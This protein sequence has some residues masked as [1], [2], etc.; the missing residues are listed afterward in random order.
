[1]KKPHPH[2]IF[3]GK[4]KQCKFAARLHSEF[5]LPLGNISLLDLL[6]NSL[7]GGE[8]ALYYFRKSSPS[9]SAGIP[10]LVNVLHSERYSFVV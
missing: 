9:L 1:M 5:F 6:E 3:T 2:P 7:K 4:N 8:R 10:V